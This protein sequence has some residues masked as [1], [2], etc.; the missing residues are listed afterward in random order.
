MWLDLR[1]PS[2]YTHNDKA[3]FLLPIDSF[4][5]KLT[6]H[7]WHLPKVNRSA[8]A[9]T[10]FWG[11]SGIQYCS[12]GLEMAVAAP[13]TGPT[14]ANDWLLLLSTDLATFYGICSTTGLHLSPFG[15]LTSS[16]VFSLPLPWLPT[17]PNQPPLCEYLWYWWKTI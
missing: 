10:V 3:Q 7:H 9:E 16:R 12:D 4:I 17:T 13:G 11:M 8:F 1:K 14:S 15:C 6:N 5:Y 2:T